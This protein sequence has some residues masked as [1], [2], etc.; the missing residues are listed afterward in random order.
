MRPSS[1]VVEK[2]MVDVEKR[3]EDEQAGEQVLF[4][5]CVEMLKAK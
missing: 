1:N 3:L 4:G 2:W 5:R